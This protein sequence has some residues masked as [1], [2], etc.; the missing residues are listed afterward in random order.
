MKT[1]L[2]LIVFTWSTTNFVHAQNENHENLK[3]LKTAFITQQLNLSPKEAESFW[4][5]YNIY[6][7]KVYELKVIR[8]K[9]ARNIIKQQGALEAISDKEAD[10]L[11]AKLIKNEEEELYAKKELF[12]GLKNVISSKKILQLQKAE[13]D[14]NRKLLKEYHKKGNRENNNP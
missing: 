4:P 10:E 13:H 7:N 6:D 11:V 8:N 14:F 9:E 2:L 3:A 12:R 1:F 5:I